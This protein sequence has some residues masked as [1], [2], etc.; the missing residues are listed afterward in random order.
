MFQLLMHKLKTAPVC[1][2]H[3]TTFALGSC[4]LLIPYSPKSAERGMV[5]TPNHQVCCAPGS[6]YSRTLDHCSLPGCLTA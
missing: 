2:N 6:T 1:F 3:N 4:V 5:R